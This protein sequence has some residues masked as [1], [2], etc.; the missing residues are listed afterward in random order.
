MAAGAITR[1]QQ[2]AIKQFE[3][4]DNGVFKCAASIPIVGVI[5]SSVA[6]HFLKQE[7]C[8]TKEACIRRIEVL[9]S[10]KI[11][12]FIST[13]L[14]V[15]IIVTLI[16]CNNIRDQNTLIITGVCSGIVL[17]HTAYHGYG[18]YRNRET[19][20]MLR[21]GADVSRNSLY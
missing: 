6:E 11:T 17:A 12:R 21:D 1:E 20:Q 7:R 15:A 19:L 8:E 4:E 18:Y 16:V 10:Y 14:F 13:F 2:D 3:F 5:M 9:N